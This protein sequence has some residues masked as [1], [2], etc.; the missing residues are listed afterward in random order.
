MSEI[1]EEVKTGTDQKPIDIKRY[2]RA[3]SLAEYLDVGLSTI[4]KLNK[5][6]KG[7]PQPTH[8]T[9]SVAVWDIT[10]VQQFMNNKIGE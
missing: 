8:L 2:Y 4:Y 1:V 6:E 7:F 9:S 3:K 10:K 5:T